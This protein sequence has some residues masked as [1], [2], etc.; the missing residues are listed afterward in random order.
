MEQ[1]RLPTGYASGYSLAPMAGITDSAMR[2]ICRGLGATATVTEMVSAAG[3]SRRSV[4]TSRLLVH[5]EEE[6]PLGVQLFGRRPEDFSR[7][8]G[9]VDGLGFDFVDI[10]AGCPVRR[11]AS[12]GSGAGLL[13][14]LPRLLRIVESVRASTRLP[15]T[16]KIRLGW[17]PEEP[18][19]PAAP[20]LLA[21]AGASAIAVH[22]RHRCDLFAG[23]VDCPGIASVVE[24]SPVPVLANGDSSCP[25]AVR[26][27]LE[28]TGASGALLGRGAV[29]NP[30]IFR[31]LAGRG[32]ARPLPGELRSTVNRQLEMMHGYIDAPH[33]YH[34]MRGHLCRYLRGFPG[35]SAVRARAV[36]VGSD[37]DVDE[38]LAMAEERLHGD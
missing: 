8:A 32:P 16:V 5:T 38:V 1:S 25:E 17:S 9:L 29:S 28:S 4:K 10:N 33:V 27:M 35:A 15:V 20:E 31:G 36:H 19:D 3:L 18:L 11:V 7:A 26:S 30:W 24:A 12:K 37:S 6:R 34:A 21:E 14:D 22:G 23:E 2:R 13:R